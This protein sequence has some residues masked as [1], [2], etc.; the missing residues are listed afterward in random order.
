MKFAK[1]TLALLASIVLLPAAYAAPAKVVFQGE[2][3]SQTCKASISGETD[4]VVLLPTVPAAELQSQGQTTGLTPFKIQ[5]TDCDPTT[6]DLKIKTKFQGIGSTE[7]GNLENI[8][9]DAN[10]ATGVSLQLTKQSDGSDPIV[11]D[12]ITEVEALTL[13]SGETAAEHEF[14]VQY[15]ADEA[16]TP[17]KVQAE[18]NYT[19]SYD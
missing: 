17:G 3:A 18:A 8:L 7:N 9:K 16:A 19:L 4:G 12:G 6:G 14:G 5:V 10:A 11:L 15:H 13:K 1:T 2:V